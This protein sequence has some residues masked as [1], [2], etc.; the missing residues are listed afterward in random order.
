MRNKNTPFDFIYAKTR[1]VREKSWGV[2]AVEWPSSGRGAEEHL[3]R[4]LIRGVRRED[5]DGRNEEK[6]V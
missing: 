4:Q 3:S 5:R 1:T 2:R 6:R